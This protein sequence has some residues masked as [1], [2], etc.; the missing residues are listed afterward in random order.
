VNFKFF[1]TAKLLG[2]PKQLD[3]GCK[4]IM[5]DFMFLYRIWGQLIGQLINIKKESAVKSAL[6]LKICGPTWARTRDHL[7]MRFKIHF[8]YFYSCLLYFPEMPDSKGF[9]Q[10]IFFKTN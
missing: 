7:I 6:S 2:Q 4:K 9:Y 10:K 8:F 1:N 5:N 3:L